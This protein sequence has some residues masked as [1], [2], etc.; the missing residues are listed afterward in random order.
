[1]R[2]AAA[3]ALGAKITKPAVAL[4]VVPSVA[5]V[6]ALLHETT[7]TSPTDGALRERLDAFVREPSPHDLA[8][9]IQFGELALAWLCARLAW[10]SESE[11]GALSAGRV[12]GEV[13]QRVERLSA[14]GQALVIRVS[15]DASELPRERFLRPNHNLI[16]A[17]RVAQHL[18]ASKPPSVILACADVDFEHVVPPPLAPGEM[19]CGPTFFGFRLHDTT[20]GTG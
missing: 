4:A 6:L 8:A 2:T 20:S 10:A 14:E 13:E 12:F 16:E 18:R 9:D 17:W 7:A 5:R 19:L 3:R 11:D 1:M 15:M